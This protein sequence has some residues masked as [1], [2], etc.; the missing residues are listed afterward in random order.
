MCSP[1]PFGRGRIELNAVP[2]AIYPALMKTLKANISYD[3]GEW[4]ESH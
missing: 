2:P 1:S 3:R 4:I